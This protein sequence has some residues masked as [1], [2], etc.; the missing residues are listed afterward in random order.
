MRAK[1]KANNLS[2]KY[3]F[4]SAGIKIIYEKE[5]PDSRTVQLGKSR[6]VH[7][8]NIFA[9]KVT[10]QDL[11]DFDLILTMTQEHID[12]V[13][14]ISPAKHYGKVRLLL[15]FCHVKNS[16]HDEVSDPFYKGK[17]DIAQT[18]DIIEL[19]INNLFTILET[20]Y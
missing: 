1:A 15:E 16:N 7:F 20:E 6:N 18:F 17:E 14:E 10:S 19:A 13:L 5:E 9:R 12:H 8:D 11:E 4:D 3:S 2:D